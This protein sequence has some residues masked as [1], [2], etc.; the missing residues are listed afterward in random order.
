[1]E[2]IGSVMVFTLVCG[3]QELLQGLVE[4][5]QEEREREKQRREEEEKIL[6][7]VWKGLVGGAVRVQ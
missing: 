5:A 7:E 1:M 6:E 4:R 2:N 3:V